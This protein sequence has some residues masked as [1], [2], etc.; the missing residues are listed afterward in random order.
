MSRVR[1]TLA[2]TASLAV[3]SM[4]LTACFAEPSAHNAIRD[5][6]VGWQ[7]GD[8]DL[9]ASRADGDPAV[10]RKALEATKLDLDAASYRFHIKSV[11]RDGDATT[12]TFSAEVD[13]GENNPLWEY[14]STLPLRL[15]NGAWKVRW[16]PSVLHPQL[17]D[18][19]RFAVKPDP[20]PRQNVL[21]RNGGA[22]QRSGRLYV[23]GVRPADLGD[24]TA[25]FVKQLAEV[26]GFAEDRLLS[27]V[28]SAPPGDFVQLATFGTDRYQR[29][30][31]KLDAITPKVTVDLQEQPVEPAS[32]REIVGRVGAL[33]PETEVKLGG[34]QR[35][36]DSVGINGLQKEYQDHLTGSTESQVITIDLKT[37]NEVAVL[38]KWDGRTNGP[39]HTTIDSR[40]QKAADEALLA[41]ES[42]A[43]VAVDAASSQI[44]AVGSKGMR[45]VN[46]VLAGKYPAG[47]AFSIIA[48]DALLKAG[49]KPSQRL[50]CPTSR[51]VG[52][53]PFVQASR[54]AGGVSAT[55]QENFAKGCV[56][57]LASLA[58]RITPDK[59]QSSAKAYGIG[60]KWKLPLKSFS[61][62]MPTLDS[63]ADEA[64][65]I[66]GQNVQVSPLTMALVAGAVKSGTWR[67]PTLVTS[68][69]APDPGTGQVAATPPAP[70]PVDPKVRSALTKMMRAGVAGNPAAQ[71]G[72]GKVY[73]VT[74]DLP[75]D[76]AWFVGWQGNVAVAVLVKNS[77]AAAVAGRFFG[78]LGNS[79]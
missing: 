59:L 9:A 11:T 23:V 74:A 7:S 79:R 44:R 5:F 12:A 21:D 14:E 71:A 48:A 68:P 26:T 33:T 78:A 16:S 36:G 6:L 25:A 53:A 3:A 1:R 72:T 15:V 46:D 69:A 64:K 57:A 42:G 47:T 54:Q 76:L 34:P 62:S 67:P 58:R 27:R 8:Y 37:G 77:D 31:A 32:P 43:V 30:K 55:F 24:N 2:A 40:L 73:G 50:R 75:D 10:V 17:K 4:T 66:A 51:T 39:V 41:A 38:K 49:V 70:V 20:E 60:V 45:Q 65:A 63:D 56:T 52:G 35:A 29:V 28:R 61:G 22:L 13:L 19:Q 18:G